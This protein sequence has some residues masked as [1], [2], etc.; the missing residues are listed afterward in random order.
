MFPSTVIETSL[1]RICGQFWFCFPVS[2]KL[3]DRKNENTILN[4][5]ANGSFNS[6]N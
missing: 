6:A 3:M 4:K 1:K 2:Y 5:H